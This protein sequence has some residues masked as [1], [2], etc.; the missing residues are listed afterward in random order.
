[1]Q[2]EADAGIPAED[3][4]VG[5]YAGIAGN[6]EAFDHAR[7]L[8]GE[9]TKI[10]RE[11][12]YERDLGFVLMWRAN[13]QLAT[14]RLDEADELIAEHLALAE[15]TGQ[16]HN[17]RWARFN[18]ARPA[19]YRGDLARAAS[20]GEQLISEGVEVGIPVAVI[21]H[22]AAGEAALY[23]RDHASAVGD[24]RRWTLRGPPACCGRSRGGGRSGA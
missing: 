1:M 16:V 20:I 12:G 6:A 19:I 23:A 14:G 24:R 22:R 18:G 21:G 15:S 7:E 5:Y 8:I 11:D 17:A 10:C 4:M 3:R 9:W 2:L 13:V